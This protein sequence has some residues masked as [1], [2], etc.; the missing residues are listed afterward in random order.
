MKKRSKINFLGF[1]QLFW[2]EK[3]DF[4]N[5]D[6][7]WKKRQKI[8][9][10]AFLQLFWREK[11]DFEN[12]DENWKKRPKINFLAFDA[13]QLGEVR[14]YTFRALLLIGIDRECH[15][16]CNNV[17]ICLCTRC[18]YSLRQSLVH[19]QADALAYLW[20]DTR[21]FLFAGFLVLYWNAWST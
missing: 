5:F 1:L 2:R 6:E 3:M 11:M 12:F 19:F 16:V 10:L 4:E 7:N 8:N 13:D 14:C 17:R 15:Y 9:F 20:D 18:R 21:K